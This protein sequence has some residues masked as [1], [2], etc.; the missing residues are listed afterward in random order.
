MEAVHEVNLVP[1]GKDEVS[2]IVQANGLHK[3]FKMTE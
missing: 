2:L 1:V 3:A